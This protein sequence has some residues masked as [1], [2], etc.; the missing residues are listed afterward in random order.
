MIIRSDGKNN[1]EIKA[2]NYEMEG[3]KIKLE[4]IETK[5]IYI[6]VI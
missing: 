2:I 5:Y 6:M 3:R 4:V 1:L